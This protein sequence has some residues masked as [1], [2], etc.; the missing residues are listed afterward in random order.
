MSKDC[1]RLNVMDLT[2]RKAQNW[3]KILTQPPSDKLLYNIL[4]RD[5]TIYLGF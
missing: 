1:T 3:N 2:H 4:L 5:S